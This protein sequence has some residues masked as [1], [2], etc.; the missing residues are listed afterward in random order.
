MPCYHP[1]RGARSG[2]GS[3]K[4]LQPGSPAGHVTVACGQCVGC[5]DERARQWAVRCMHEASLHDRNCVVTLTYAPEHVP[6]SGSL[7][8]RDFQLFMKRLRKRMGHSIRFFMCGEY[9][10]EKG[11]PHFHSLLF[12]CD[13]AADRV[14]FKTAGEDRSR[15]LYTSSTL[16][17]LWKYGHS[18][19]GEMSFASAAY[20][21]RY[22]LKKVNGDAADDWYRRVDEGTGEVFDLEPEFCSMSLRPGIGA[23]WYERFWPEVVRSGTCVLNGV[24]GNAPRFYMRRLRKRDEGQYKVVMQKRFRDGLL[25]VGDQTPERLVAAGEVHKAKLRSYKRQLT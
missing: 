17:E 20:V 14:A 11:R 15:W 7:F 16:S 1:L 22:V 4:S 12:G 8:Y 25:R 10:D 3:V 23:D 13:F 6:V 5:R 18:S 2:N 21:A 24:E 9:G 19:V